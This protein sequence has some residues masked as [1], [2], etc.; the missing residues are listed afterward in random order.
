[1]AIVV[2]C[3]STTWVP[4][5][6]QPDARS[7]RNGRLA[8]P[9]QWRGADAQFIGA[10]RRQARRDDRVPLAGWVPVVPGADLSGPAAGVAGPPADRGAHRSG[11]AR[12]HPYRHGRADRLCRA[13]LLPAARSAVHHELYDAVSRIHLGPLA[14]P[15]SV[16]LRHIALVPFGGGGDDGGDA[17]AHD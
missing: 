9:G 13:L 15:A 16:D 8:A 17:V 6:E 4:G 3:D 2:A 7:R 5:G 12:R 14:D 11:A 10:R 1:M